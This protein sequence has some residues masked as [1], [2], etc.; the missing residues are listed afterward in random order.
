[1]SEPAKVNE[2]ND[3]LLKIQLIRILIYDYDTRQWLRTDK[4]I[5]Y[6]REFYE[7]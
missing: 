6:N 7:N 3:V 4:N 2:Y 5:L 1:M